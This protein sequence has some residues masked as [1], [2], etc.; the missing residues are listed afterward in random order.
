M[1]GSKVAAIF[2]VLGALICGYYNIEAVFFPPGD[3]AVPRSTAINESAAVKGIE[4]VSLEI[5]NN[6]PWYRAM[7]SDTN[8]VIVPDESYFIGQLSDEG[9]IVLNARVD[10][11][12]FY[13]KREVLLSFWGLNKNLAKPLLWEEFHPN[14]EGY[15][16]RRITEN[17]IIF[18][19]D[20]WEAIFISFLGMILGFAFAIIAWQWSSHATRRHGDL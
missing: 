4:F 10:K 17:E 3:I 11:K 2:F 16:V 14:P 15:A 9:I 8:P 20:V 13:G 19:Y 7:M 6:D 1:K 18:T 5:A 12:D